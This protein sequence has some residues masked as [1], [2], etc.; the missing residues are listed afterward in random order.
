MLGYLRELYEIYA[1]GATVP[2]APRPEQ[3]TTEPS[4]TAPSTP[5]PPATAATPPPAA[6]AAPKVSVP[7][8]PPPPTPEAPVYAQ[9]PPK[10]QPPVQVTPPTPPPPPP[11]IP[12]PAPTPVAAA[13]R[14]VPPP[15]PT[16]APA[17]A[18]K[19]MAPAPSKH[20]PTGAAAV[21][22]EDT[23]AT[24]RF[25]RMPLNDLTKALSI[26]NRILFS[27]DLFGGENE[28]LSDT[29]QQLNS[30]RDMDEAM[31]LLTTMV[32]RFDWTE[33]HKQEHAKEFIELVRR[34]Y[35]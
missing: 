29:L 22:F 35:A 15:P 24:G 14:P 12:E 30:C 21:L 5:P 27:R 19:R 13:P 4:T 9:E 18:P 16:P 25:G 3:K 20:K 11:A 33:E 32:Q 8:T 31:P 23:G 1:E 10:V 2:P 26:N 17:A 34:R 28:L 7:P 6:I